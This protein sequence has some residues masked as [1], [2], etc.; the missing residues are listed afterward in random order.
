M[1]EKSVDDYWNVD[2]DRELADM[3][4]GFTRFTFFWAKS[5]WMD[6]RVPGRDWQKKPNDLQARQNMARNVETYVWGIKTEREAKVGYRE[7][8]AR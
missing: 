1:L 6:V 2:G 8:K 3:W 5:H 7:T 4:T